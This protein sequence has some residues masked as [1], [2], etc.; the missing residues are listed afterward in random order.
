[1]N[2][3]LIAVITSIGFIAAYFLYGRFLS[4]KIF[5]LFP[6]DQTPAH[7]MEDGVDFV[8]TNRFVL[9]GHHFASIA[10]LGPIIGP[11]IAV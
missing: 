10:G 9:F 7:Q 2:A 5:E 1:M 3:I 11:A 6:T 4:R 8:P